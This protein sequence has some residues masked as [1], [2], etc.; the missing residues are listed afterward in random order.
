MTGSDRSQ[1]GGITY[2]LAVRRLL[3]VLVFV[4]CGDAPTCNQALG[5]AGPL[6]GIED[7]DATIAACEQKGWRG[8]VR[9]CLAKATSQSEAVACTDPVKAD[10]A[11]VLIDQADKAVKESARVERDAEHAKSA[12]AP[13]ASVAD[14]AHQL[15]DL[16]TRVDTE[17]AA[18]A[19]SKNGAELET[20]Q[21]RLVVLQRESAAVKEKLD[22]VMAARGSGL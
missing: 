6:L 4:G 11:M 22:I 8:D 3:C 21:E 1:I 15:E 18:V 20:N 12:A 13:R 7:I 17:F 14:L 5:H 19:S 2:D 10:I 9:T 16:R